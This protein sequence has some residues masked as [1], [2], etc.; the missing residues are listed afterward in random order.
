MYDKR[1]RK[2]SYFNEE[3]KTRGVMKRVIPLVISPTDEL[4][5]LTK[6]LFSSSVKINR[7]LY[8]EIQQ[9]EVLS[10]AQA[11]GWGFIKR[12][13]LELKSIVSRTDHLE[14]IVYR[15]VE[16][17]I[18]GQRRNK[19]LAKRPIR[20]HPDKAL[21]MRKGASKVKKEDM[22]ISFAKFGGERE[23]FDI[24]FIVPAYFKKWFENCKLGE[25][26]NLT[27]MSRK[28][29][30]LAFCST[31]FIDW[32]Y[33]P[34]SFLGIDLNQ[35]GEIFLAC[36]E[37]LLDGRDVLPHNDE[38]VDI[39]SNLRKI[40]KDIDNHDKQTLLTT[41]DRKLMRDKWKKLHQ[42]LK[43]ALNPYVELLVETTKTNRSVLCIDDAK[44]GS[45]S[46]SY[47][48]EISDI[49]RQRCENEGVPFMMVPCAYTSKY[50]AECHTIYINKKCRTKDWETFICPECGETNADIKA[51]QNIALF[52]QKIWEEGEQSFVDWF[53]TIPV[54]DNEPMMVAF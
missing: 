18:S 10:N 7:L 32:Q 38:V 21:R 15:L 47:G 36:S 41:Q 6:H 27:N 22:I 43:E 44:T 2:N 54:N 3:W 11:L 37:Q 50:C 20:L 5:E 35:R 46:G 39:V 53:N 52:G 40:N 28:N 49:L 12:N 17:Y 31:I 25:S 8:K 14:S 16:S 34:T 48:Q 33:E 9:E 30:V 29:W 24:P 4:R 42:Q 45:K 13:R 19:R 51:A 1:V 26:G 23:R